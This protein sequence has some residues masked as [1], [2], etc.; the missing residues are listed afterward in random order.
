MIKPK[1]PKYA[2]NALIKLID[3]HARNA[4]RAELLRLEA[5]CKTVSQPTTPE[6]FRASIDAHV[7]KALGGINR[8]VQ[9]E[10]KARVVAI[11]RDRELRERL[12]SSW[13]DLP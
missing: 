12:E 3:A 9:T 1:Y 4:P 5:R 8:N 11:N 10:Q 2:S 7:S 6:K 13:E